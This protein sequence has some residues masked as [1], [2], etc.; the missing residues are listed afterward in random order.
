MEKRVF[1]EGED[2][3]GAE[4]VGEWMRAVRRRGTVGIGW[5]VDGRER[6][7]VREVERRGS[8]GRKA[9]LEKDMARLG[10][11]RRK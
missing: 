1:G 2:V 10:G 4:H 6:R 7:E 3:T 5:R 9:S 8:A 11:G